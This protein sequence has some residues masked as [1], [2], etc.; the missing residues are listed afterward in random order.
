MTGK[1]SLCL[2]TLDKKNL[3]HHPEMIFES[4]QKSKCLGHTSRKTKL[5]V[6]Q[7]EYCAPNKWNCIEETDSQFCQET[8]KTF[9]ACKVYRNKLCS[10]S[11]GSQ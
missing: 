10:D 1:H 11:T 3:Q 7:G 8:E 9:C 2:T 5:F 6:G 4:N